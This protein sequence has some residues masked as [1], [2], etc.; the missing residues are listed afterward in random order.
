MNSQTQ[1]VKYPCCPNPEE[2]AC[3]HCLKKYLDESYKH[4][5]DYFAWEGCNGEGVECSCG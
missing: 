1:V 3:T 4:P 5:L 2:R